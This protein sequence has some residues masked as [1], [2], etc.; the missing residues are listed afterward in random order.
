MKATPFFTRITKIKFFL[1]QQF[2][3]R[4][5]LL[6]CWDSLLTLDVTRY[7]CSCLLFRKWLFKSTWFISLVLVFDYSPSPLL[8]NLLFTYDC[9]LYYYDWVYN[10]LWLLLIIFREKTVMK[11]TGDKIQQVSWSWNLPPDFTDK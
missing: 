8:T 1:Y 10:F 2:R 5:L 3:N 4:K 9:F 11:T 7:F 6:R